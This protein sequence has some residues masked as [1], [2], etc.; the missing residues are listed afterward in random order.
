[1][2][3]RGE[4]FRQLLESD[5]CDSIS[6]KQTIVEIAGENRVLIENHGGVSGYSGEQIIVKVQYGNICICGC[7][8]RL[9]RMTKDQVIVCGNIHS[10]AL[11]RGER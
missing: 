9:M 7:E 1:M 2:N 5:L 11:Q 10:V 8:L 6:S 4:F 3:K